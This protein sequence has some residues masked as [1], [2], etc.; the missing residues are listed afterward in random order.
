MEW[1][2]SHREET[3][4]LFRF[5]AENVECKLLKKENLKVL[6]SELART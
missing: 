6:T 3:R 5:A 2:E 4:K 1:V